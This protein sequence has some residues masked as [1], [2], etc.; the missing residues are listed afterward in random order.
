[1]PPFVIRGLREVYVRLGIGLPPVFVG[2]AL[3]GAVLA[4][5][6]V[7]RGFERPATRWV[8]RSLGATG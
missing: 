7:H 1:M 8:R 4:A 3:A 2:L 6:A 5:L